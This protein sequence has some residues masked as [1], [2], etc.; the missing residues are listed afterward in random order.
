MAFL[1]FVHNSVCI[2]FL[3]VWKQ[4]NLLSAQMAKILIL[5]S[6]EMSMW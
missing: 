4:G 1:I 5:A 6:E 2:P 3:D